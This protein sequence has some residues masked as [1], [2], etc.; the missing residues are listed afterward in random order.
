MVLNVETSFALVVTVYA[1]NW[2]ENSFLI[3]C[4]TGILNLYLWSNI[5]P[6][7]SQSMCVI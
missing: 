6:L 2:Y 7:E 5:L 4:F 3:F 1:N